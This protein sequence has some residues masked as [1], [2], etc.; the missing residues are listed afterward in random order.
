MKKC[1]Q[2]A[3]QVQDEAKVCR[4]CGSRL[5]RPRSAAGSLWGIV[6]ISVLAIAVALVIPDERP[7]TAL[8]SNRF[9]S[10]PPREICDHSARTLASMTASSAGRFSVVGNGLVVIDDAAWSIIPSNE[11]ATLARLVAYDA[12]CP[13][14]DPNEIVVRVK[15][16]RTNKV[17]ASGTVA[18]FAER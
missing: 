11:K 2:C 7:P 5:P 6:A 9:A 16:G 4:Y 12:A 3:E 8:K 10:G 13:T 17:L 18:S 14:G 15:S 1:P